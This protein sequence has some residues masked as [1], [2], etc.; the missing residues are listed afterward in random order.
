VLGLGQKIASDSLGEGARV[1]DD[2]DLARSLRGVHA[3]GTE[4]FQLRRG[5][6]VVA[7]AD[8]LVHGRD[9]LRP[10]SHR[11]HRLRPPDNVDLAEPEQPRYGEHP[12]AHPTVGAGRCADADLPHPRD[13]GRYRRHHQR[14]RVGCVPAW[15]VDA[16]PPQ[17]A[18]PLSHRRAVAAHLPGTVQLP[19][20]ESAHVL[21]GGQE[22]LFDLRGQR[23]A[24]A[25]DLLA[26]NTEPLRPHAVEALG[27]LQQ[28]LV[29]PIPDV[30]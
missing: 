28:R 2:H 13:L 27:V 4:D 21:E 7:G 1:G 5:H 29:A 10:V 9:G 19:L 24:G 6:V 14:A 17:G 20:V 25:F 22:R 11:P 26:R 23:R 18:H 8:D 3:H 15:Y 16:G 30:T 12:P